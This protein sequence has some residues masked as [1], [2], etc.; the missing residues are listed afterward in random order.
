MPN[1]LI[2]LIGI[3]VA[4][5]ISLFL[6]RIVARLSARAYQSLTREV[7]GV[8]ATISGGG[9]SAVEQVV[10]LGLTLVVVILLVKFLLRRRI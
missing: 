4:F 3:L 5:A 7:D 10:S 6:I 8:I 9:S 1:W 2:R